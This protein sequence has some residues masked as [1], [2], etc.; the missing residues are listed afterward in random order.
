MPDTLPS[1]LYVLSH[2]IL[3]V[4]QKVGIIVALTL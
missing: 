3:P 2:L 4:S 1:T